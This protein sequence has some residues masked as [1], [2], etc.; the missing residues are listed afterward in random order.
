M[1]STQQQQRQRQQQQHP[2]PFAAM[3]LQSPIEATSQ[4]VSPHSPYAAADAFAQ[5][6]LSNP[7]A[8]WVRTC[9]VH[10]HRNDSR[11]VVNGLRFSGLSSPL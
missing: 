9:H 1:S 5:V 8:Y 10:V 3:T 2:F 11:A 6:H 7:G 4:Y